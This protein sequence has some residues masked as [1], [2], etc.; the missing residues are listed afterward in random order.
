[1]KSARRS[2]RASL[3]ERRD[4]SFSMDGKRRRL[5]RHKVDT[6]LSA[7][8]VADEVCVVRPKF[9]LSVSA[10]LFGV[11]YPVFSNLNV[12]ASVLLFY[13][14]YSQLSALGRIGLRSGARKGRKREGR[15]S[16]VDLLG[17]TFLPSVRFRGYE[18]LVREHQSSIRYLQGLPE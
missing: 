7:C 14:T 10:H 5:G 8:L 3:G 2:I 16:I 12:G 9:R 4:E 18:L 1:M 17:A 15:R 11:F 6:I 13:S